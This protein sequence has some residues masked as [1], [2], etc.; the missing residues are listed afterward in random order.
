MGVAEVK[1]GSVAAAST[2]NATIESVVAAMGGSACVGQNGWDVDFAGRAY[3]CA[4]TTMGN[5]WRSG[6]CMASRQGV[7]SECGSCMGQLLHC[8]TQC[9]S[10]CGYGRHVDAPK[11]IEC[12]RRLCRDDF[13]QCAGVDTPPR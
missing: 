11:C 5:A 3:R 1:A 13:I 6:R 9:A 2:P 12:G 7:S 10:P 8:G 4:F